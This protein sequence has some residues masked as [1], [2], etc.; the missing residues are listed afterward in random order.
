MSWR[1]VDVNPSNDDWKPK[2]EVVYDGTN[3]VDARIF[4][5]KWV[6]NKERGI[7]LSEIIIQRGGK[8]YIKWLMESISDKLDADIADDFAEA[9]QE[10]VDSY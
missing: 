4:F 1:A 7:L 9:C 5:G 10:I 8:G 3:A 2:V 6:I